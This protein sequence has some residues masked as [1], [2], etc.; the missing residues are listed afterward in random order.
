MLKK[1]S[2]TEVRATSGA[3]MMI[4]RMALALSPPIDGS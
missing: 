2:Q 4:L 1:A 3:Q